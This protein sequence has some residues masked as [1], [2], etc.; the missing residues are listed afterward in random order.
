MV[1]VSMIARKSV[2]A[3]TSA[4]E[5]GHCW[6]TIKPQRLGLRLFI[7]RPCNFFFE[8]NEFELS[9]PYTNR[10]WNVHM[11]ILITTFDKVIR[12]LVNA[13]RKY[14]KMLVCF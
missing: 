2:K 11:K 5:G 14:L 10:F 4:H 6:K 7:L 12:D 3:G 13:V 8:F 9:W 1:V